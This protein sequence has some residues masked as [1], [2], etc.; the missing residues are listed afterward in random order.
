MRPTGRY[1]QRTYD[2][3]GDG[4]GA[5]SEPAGKYVLDKIHCARYSSV[6]GEVLMLGRRELGKW[7]TLAHDPL[8]LI[9]Q[10]LTAMT[11]I[12]FAALNDCARS[13]SGCDRNMACLNLM[14]VISAG[15]AGAPRPSPSSRRYYYWE[16][17]WQGMAW[18]PSQARHL[19]IPDD[20]INDPPPDLMQNLRSLGMWQTTEAEYDRASVWR[21]SISNCKERAEPVRQEQP[22][23]AAYCNKAVTC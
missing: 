14:P 5:H 23:P 17:R 6:K 16:F 19:C 7:K 18:S 1:G 22:L 13:P 20:S 12:R 8:S 9:S 2:G 10:A 11:E 3:V 21:L 4:A 15:L